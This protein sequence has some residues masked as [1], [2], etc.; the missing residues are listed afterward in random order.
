MRLILIE[1][2]GKPHDETCSSHVKRSKKWVALILIIYCN[3]LYPK[4][5][6]FNV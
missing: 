1:M 3:V 2:E 5:Y 6:H 4:Y